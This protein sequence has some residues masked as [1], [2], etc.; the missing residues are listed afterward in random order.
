MRYALSLVSLAL[1]CVAQAAVV[2][3]IVLEGKDYHWTAMS[4]PWHNYP[5]CGAPVIHDEPKW[6]PA[7][8]QDC[9][10]LIDRL[11]QEEDSGIT[12]KGWVNNDPETRF[13]D[14]WSM[15]ET[16]N[17]CQIAARPIDVTKGYATMTYG[18]IANV[19]AAAM[20]SVP[21]DKDTLKVSGGVTCTVAEGNDLANLHY[22]LEPRQFEWGLFKYGSVDLIPYTWYSDKWPR[23]T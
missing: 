6:E 11:R 2:Q 15:A 21:T 1:S 10:K 19:I 23:T 22:I 9:Q 17:Q 16:G 20:A 14:L 7:P 13:I 4:R 8:R 18:D 5:F 12:L 3:R